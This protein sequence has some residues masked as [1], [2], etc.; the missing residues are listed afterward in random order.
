MPDA[1]TTRSTPRGLNSSISHVIFDFDGTLSWLRHGWPQIMYDIFR[2]HWPERAGETEETI[3]EALMS[4]ILGLNGKPTIFQM[5]TFVERVGTRGGR[6][7]SAS[8]LLEEYQTALDHKITERTAAMRQRDR[9]ADAFVVH[10][11]RSFLEKLEARG[12]A[13][14]ILSGTIEHRVKEEA[15]LLDLARYFDH[16]IYGSTPDPSQFS[17]QRVIERLLR[18][19]QIQGEH[20]VSFGDGPVEIECTRAVGGLAIGVA[21]DEERNGSGEIDRWKERELRTAGAQHV[22]ADYREPDRI[23][24]WMNLVPDA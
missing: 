15:A 23:L 5:T 17:K 19:E 4:N 13:L 22:I 14:V 20:L 6:C 18:E 2:R 10:G 21:S 12:V 3:R 11:A 7:P 9:K 8:A 1:S 24:Q 16:H